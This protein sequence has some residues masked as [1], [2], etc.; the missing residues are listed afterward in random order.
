MDDSDSTA[1]LALVDVLRVLYDTN[2]TKEQISSWLQE[3]LDTRQFKRLIEYGIKK[4]DKQH[5]DSHLLTNLC[6]N[7]EWISQKS[8]NNQRI[9]TDTDQKSIQSVPVGTRR[10]SIQ[11]N[12]SIVGATKVFHIEELTLHMFQFLDF[13]SFLRCRRT[14]RRWFYDSYHVRSIVNVNISDLHYISKKCSNYNG[15]LKDEIPSIAEDT[16]CTHED[17]TKICTMLHLGPIEGNCSRINIDCWCK[18]ILQSNKK[19]S[20]WDD[21]V[22]LM[23]NFGQSKLTRISINI[24][25]FRCKKPYDIISRLYS[26]SNWLTW[27]TLTQK[28]KTIDDNCGASCSKVLKHLD[29]YLCNNVVMNDWNGWQYNPNVCQ[30]IFEGLNY[31]IVTQTAKLLNVTQNWDKVLTK[32]TPMCN[33]I[34]G[35]FIVLCIDTCYSKTLNLWKNVDLDITKSKKMIKTMQ[36]LYKWYICGGIEAVLWYKIKHIESEL[37]ITDD[38]NTSDNDNNDHNENVR[39]L[40][41]E[42]KWVRLVIRIFKHVFKDVIKDG[43]INTLEALLTPMAET[44]KSNTRNEG[45][46]K[47]SIPDSIGWQLN[48][49][50]DLFLTSTSYNYEASGQR[51]FIE[52]KIILK[53]E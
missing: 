32:L 2:T 51:T 43:H 50:I 46:C 34:S 19:Q 16:V 8:T 13:Q 38:I 3:T 20:D 44:D 14:N 48:D 1:I 42:A 9:S 7:V 15:Y 23:D 11:T 22:S 10:S 30:K 45:D 35:I 6:N 25:K 24:S 40:F 5:K 36:I 49:R 31:I 33:K 27:L 12:S 26:L 21:L 17:M 39:Q 4:Y 47:D 37:A 41:K 52:M 28:W 29:L 18:S 53:A